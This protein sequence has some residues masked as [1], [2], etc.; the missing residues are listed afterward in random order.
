M[1]TKWSACPF[2]F[3]MPQLLLLVHGNNVIW[4]EE[5]YLYSNCRLDW[6]YHVRS[7]IGIYLFWP[8][9]CLLSP[10][11]TQISDSLAGRTSHW[12]KSKARYGSASSRWFFYVIKPYPE[13]AIVRRISQKG[14]AEGAIANRVSKKETRKYEISESP[15]LIRRAC[16]VVNGVKWAKIGLN[17]V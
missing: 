8:K 11:F 2:V 15:Q 10:L 5:S 1:T 16:T 12:V 9:L 4:N 17:Y 13:M 6:S 14:W 7:W 3:Q